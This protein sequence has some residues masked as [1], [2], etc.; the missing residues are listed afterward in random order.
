M[1]FECL[2]YERKDGT[3]Y[4]TLNRSDKLNALNAQLMAELREALETIDLDPEIA[5]SS[6][7]VPAGLSPLDSISIK[8]PAGL[9]L[10]VKN[11]MSG[12]GICRATSTR[13]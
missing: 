1:A 2:T 5:W 7:S 9:R 4:L 12:G 10:R 11:R 13:L 8:A 3:C 6:S